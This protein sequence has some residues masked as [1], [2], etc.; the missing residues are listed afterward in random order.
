MKKADLLKEIEALKRRV[1]ALE[2]KPGITY[3]P[4]VAPCP[5]VFPTY[6]SYPWVGAESVAADSVS[7]TTATGTLLAS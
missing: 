5:T 7:L 4:I 3:Y 1:E 2:A 6:P